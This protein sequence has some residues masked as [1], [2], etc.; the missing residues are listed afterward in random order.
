M[1][2]RRRKVG[3]VLGTVVGPVQVQAGNRSEVVQAAEPAALVVVRVPNYD[4]TK[5][6]ALTLTDA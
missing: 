3:T 2:N 5:T 6:Y 4:P 1:S